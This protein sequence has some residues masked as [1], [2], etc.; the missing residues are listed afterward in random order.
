MELYTLLPVR[1][2]PPV[3]ARRA[4]HSLP[5]TRCPLLAA[6]RQ[7]LG[8]ILFSFRAASLPFAFSTGGVVAMTATESD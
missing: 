1:F 7:P 4:S 6:R 3:I 8:P 2:S 5:A